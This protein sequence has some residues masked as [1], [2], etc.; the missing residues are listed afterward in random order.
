MN[1]G[2][3]MLTVG[4]LALLSVITLNYFAT[5]G[6]SG[7][8]IAQSN[9]GLTATTIATSFIERAQNTAFDENDSTA[10]NLI[11]ANHALLTAPGSLGADAGETELDSL[12][13]F[14]DFNFYHSGNPFVYTPPKLNEIYNVWFNVYYVDTN[15]INASSGVGY[16]TFLKKMDV[17]VRGIYPDTIAPVTL[18]SIYGLFSF[19]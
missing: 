3:L 14:D 16:Q 18:S 8:N 7:E 17:T 6:Q 9:A 12:D 5:L 10:I 1:T 4:A 13:D 2:Q 19:N 11:I 15:N